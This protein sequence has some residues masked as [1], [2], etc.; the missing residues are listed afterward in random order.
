MPTTP[1]RAENP[2][3]PVNL[4]VRTEIRS[5]IDTAARIQ[6]KSRSDFMIDAARRAAE[7][8]VLDQTLL[9]VDLTTFDQFV[10]LLDRPA[11]GPGVERLLNA[12]APWSQ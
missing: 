8:A 10:E 12:R 4:R 11:S 6:G 2:A 5:L 3:K 1:S 7:E 9:R